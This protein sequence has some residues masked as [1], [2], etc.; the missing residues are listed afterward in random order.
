M[1]LLTGKNINFRTPFRSHTAIPDTDQL[2]KKFASS[3]LIVL[4]IILFASIFIFP[5]VAALFNRASL[6]VSEFGILLVSVS[7]AVYL[8]LFFIARF[9]RSAARYRTAHSLDRAGE[10]T[11]G[12]I[13]DKWMDETN[14]TPVYYVRYKYTVHVNAKQ[15]IDKATYEKLN[16]KDTACILY[17]ENLPHIS[18]LEL[19]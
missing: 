18:R 7:I 17:L 14:G 12:S 10:I 19:E 3:F 11:H 16:R 1:K 8:L 6:S 15:K 2:I 13:V 4:L 5:R 9:F